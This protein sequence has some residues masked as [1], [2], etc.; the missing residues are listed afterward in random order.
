[1]FFLINPARKRRKKKKGARKMARYR[2]RGRGGRFVKGGTRKRR[3]RRA[4][5]YA[6]PRRRRRR[7]SKRRR[8]SPRSVRFTPVR[9][10]RRVYRR[11]P[12]IRSMGRGIVGKVMGGATRGLQVTLGRAGV[13]IVVGFL[14]AGLQGPGIV[15]YATKAVG[16]VVVGMAADA[17]GFRAASPFVVAGAF[18]TIWD[19]V[20]RTFN[21]PL[22]APALSGYP[23]M[24]AGMTGYPQL[25][26][27]ISG[28]VLAPENDM[29]AG[30][31]F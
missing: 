8:S 29:G 12:G 6:A 18:S 25:A 15:G 20:I 16:A 10:P 22:L 4:V 28:D 2:K 11:N 24:A 14:P 27:G 26:S 5:A 19:D 23:Q 1:M 21:V 30:T 9:L 31:L 17:L 3:R 13:N 7:S